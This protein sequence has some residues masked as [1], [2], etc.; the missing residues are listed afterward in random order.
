ME[1]EKKLISV[2][3]PVYNVK[4]YIRECIDSVLAQ[5]YTELE[6]LLVDDGS[7]D[8][9]GR[10]CDEYA[11]KD[12]RILVIHRKNG[13]LSAARN[14]G[15]RECR[16]EYVSFIDSDDAVSP[17]FIER[18]YDMC[19]ESGCDIAIGGIKVAGGKDG[20]T[21]ES[22]L[23]GSASDAGQTDKAQA[24]KSCSVK[25]YTSREL[26]DIFYEPDMHHNIVVA[27]NKLYRRE[28]IADIRYPEGL[29]YEDEATTH[30][31]IYNAKK[32]SYTE[33]KLYFYRNRPGSITTSGFSLKRLDVLEAYR[34]RRQFY[35]EHNEKAYAVR[36][37]YCQLSAYLEFYRILGRKLPEEKKVRRELLDTFRNLYRNYDKSAWGLK[38]RML[39][40]ACFLCPSFYGVMN[41][42]KS[43]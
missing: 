6:I 39:Y 38:R 43:K 11:E 26:L 2:I 17:I 1:T 28:V 34:R 12:T 10:I 31:F 23:S 14:S 3:I 27:W 21:M 29:V 5:T 9:S 15:I 35:L 25:E 19:L 18:L 13:G 20:V 30:A 36:E 40:T 8:D 37:E 42:V 33:E 41:S 24:V 4:D 16:G 7:T 22:L 32:L